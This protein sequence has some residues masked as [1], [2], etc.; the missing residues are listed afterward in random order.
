MKNAIFVADAVLLMMAFVLAALL[1]KRFRYGYIAMIVC[2]GAAAYGLHYGRQYSWLLLG[3][4]CI[5]AAIPLV[6]AL[7]GNYLA[8]ETKESIVEKRLWR[9]LFIVLAILGTVG[10]FFLETQLDA[11]HKKELTDLQGNINDDLFSALA[12]YNAT[13]P[14]HPITVEQMKS[15]VS[16]SAPKVVVPPLPE[17]A[18]IVFSFWDDDREKLE[19]EFPVVTTTAY[20]DNGVAHVRITNEV[21]NDVTARNGVI[22]IRLCTGCSFASEIPGE[23][24][25]VKESPEDRSIP[26]AQIFPNIFDV[27]VDIAINP[28]PLS[29]LIRN[30]IT[31][32][33]AYACENCPPIDMHHAQVL[34]IKLS[35]TL[36]EIL[37]Q[38]PV[39]RP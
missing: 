13:H 2:A 38:K 31:L 6:M 10:S 28:P 32:A 39:K 21:R 20:L 11:E 34:T 37:K 23:S 3:K 24:P 27:P 5:N 12:R 4:I 7:L 22:A 9:S 15:I 35:G 17:K 26:F 30:P 14:E 25:P 18:K 36:H 19:A 8:A 1:G 33:L 16:A 29:Q